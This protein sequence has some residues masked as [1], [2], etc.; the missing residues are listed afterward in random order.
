MAEQVQSSK[1]LTVWLGAINLAL[2]VAGFSCLA[3]GVYALASAKDI[4]ITGTGLTAGLVLLLAA[5]IERF[6]V[7]KGLGM[8]AKT[9]KLDVALSQATA[10]LDQLREL[11]ELSSDFV[12]PL[13]VNAGRWDSGTSTKD[14]Y[15]IAQRVKRNLV[16]LGSTDAAV[17]KT[18]APWVTMTSNDLSR[19][20]MKAALHQMDLGVQHYSIQLRNLQAAPEGGTQA[21]QASLDAMNRFVQFRQQHMGDVHDWSIGTHAA[22]LRNIFELMPLLEGTER[23]TL[24]ASIAPWL[25]RLDFLAANYDLSDKEQWF[26]MLKD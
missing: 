23:T 9:R 8:E 25:P 19:E 12:I 26:A 13:V 20:L 18:L 11:A 3:I 24:F 17:R 4:A 1:L 22:K 21:N 15:E 7:L 6:E 5:S 10:S 14:A 2:G 16:G